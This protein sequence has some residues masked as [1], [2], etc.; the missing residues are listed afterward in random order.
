MASALVR[1]G[2]V[3]LTKGRRTSAARFH[4]THEKSAHWCGKVLWYPQKVAALVRQGFGVVG[5]VNG[6]LL[7]FLLDFCVCY[8]YFYL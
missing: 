7:S 3:V 1:Q 2:F 4:G 5:G 8:N 6:K